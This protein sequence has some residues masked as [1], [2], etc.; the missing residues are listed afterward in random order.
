[1][2]LPSFSFPFKTVFS[3]YVP[4]PPLTHTHMH[5]QYFMKVLINFPPI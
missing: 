4:P 3:I 2:T 1:M 5:F